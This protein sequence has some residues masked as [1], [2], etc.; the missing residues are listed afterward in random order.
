MKVWY[1]SVKVI[2]KQQLAS[3]K[4]H[5]LKL[6]LNSNSLPPANNVPNNWW[7]FSS[8]PA[9][10]QKS[11]VNFVEIEKLFPLQEAMCNYNKT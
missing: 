3:L 9:Y 7:R 1:E 2:R 6:V 10:D 11:V 8:L 5:C 4:T